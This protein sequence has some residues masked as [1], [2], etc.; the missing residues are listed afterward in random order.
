MWFR[1][2]LLRDEGLLRNFFDRDLS[3]LVDRSFT[4]ACLHSMES[5]WTSQVLSLASNI[6]EIMEEELIVKHSIFRT[7]FHSKARAPDLLSYKKVIF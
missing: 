3:F 2:N 7:M 1:P 6:V 4:P 5:A